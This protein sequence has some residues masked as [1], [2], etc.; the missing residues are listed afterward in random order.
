VK[1]QSNALPELVTGLVLPV[2]ISLPTLSAGSGRNIA[3]QF[4]EDDEEEEGQVYLQDATPFPFEGK[5][6]KEDGYRE[7]CHKLHSPQYVSTGWQSRGF[8]P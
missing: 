4:S 5:R 8:F 3:L 6:E 2:G 1:K 7:T